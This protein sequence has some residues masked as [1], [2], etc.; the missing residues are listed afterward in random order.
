MMID[1]YVII[2]R[3]S[4]E[5]THSKAYTSLRDAKLALKYHHGGPYV[6]NYAV[7]KISAIPSAMYAVRSDG[8]WME[9]S[10]E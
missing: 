3:P 9:V 10:A 6:S 4:G 2:R 1:T 7:V 8:K 5:L